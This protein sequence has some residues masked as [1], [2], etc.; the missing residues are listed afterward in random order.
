MYMNVAYLSVMFMHVYT[1]A[2][3]PM[4]ML[5]EDRGH[6]VLLSYSFEAGS[7]TQPG[8]RLAGGLQALVILLS[9]QCLGCRC[10]PDHT[11]FF[12]VFVFFNKGVGI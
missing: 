12:F 11:C 2:C 3:P 8:D 1:G 5:V 10:V 7:P 6:I 9:P 4:C